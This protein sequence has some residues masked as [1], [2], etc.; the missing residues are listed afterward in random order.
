MQNLKNKLTNDKTIKVII[1]LVAIALI[2]LAVFYYVD[3]TKQKPEET[4]GTKIE[5]KEGVINK[6]TFGG[7]NEETTYTNSILPTLKITDNS[8]NAWEVSENLLNKTDK[9]FNYSI[10]FKNKNINIVF[11][12]M[13]DN[14]TLEA[15]KTCFDESDLSMLNNIWTREKMTD[16]SGQQIGYI[17][18]K[19]GSYSKRDNANFDKYYDEYI[20]FTKQSKL[21]SRLKELAYACSTASR[22]NPIDYINASS[23]KSQGLVRIFVNKVNDNLTNEELSI[24][25]NF[26]KNVSF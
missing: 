25:D 16:V 1:V 11:S 4:K 5:Y 6:K 17:F 8:S 23:N 10:I 2:A 3:S 24:V 21:P 26:V 22:M 18:M 15:G 7:Q 12:V 14:R 19:N 20:A 13:N 9:S